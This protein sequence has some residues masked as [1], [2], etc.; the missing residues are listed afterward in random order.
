MSSI[1]SKLTSI[2]SDV[3]TIPVSDLGVNDKLVDYGF[4]SISLTKLSNEIYI[5]LGIETTPAILIE[6]ESIGAMAKYLEGAVGANEKNNTII[7]PITNNLSAPP[8]DSIFDTASKSNSLSGTNSFA[9]PR[10]NVFENNIVEQSKTS[11]QFVIATK[12][13]SKNIAIIGMSGEFPGA[14]NPQQLWQL[15]ESGQSPIKSPPKERNKLFMNVSP[16]AAGWPEDYKGGF[17]EDI[18]KFDASFFNISPREAKYLD[19]QHRLLLKHSLIALEEAGYPPKALAEKKVG[20]FIGI[21]TTDYRNIVESVGAYDSHYTTGAAHTMSANRISYFLGVT[22][23]SFIIDTAC[24]SSLVATHQAVLAIQNGDCDMAIVGG[25]NA[26]LHPG[27][28]H[29]C[30]EAG[31]LSQTGSCKVF[32]EQAD[33]YVRAEGCGV[34]ILKS[35]KQAAIDKDNILAVIRGSA[36]NHGGHVRSLTVPNP[37]AQAEV[38]KMALERAELTSEDISYI[39]THGTGTKIGDPVEVNGLKRSITKT[40]RYHRCG[41]GSVKANIGHLEAG[42]GMVGLIKVILMFKH[43]QLLKNINLKTQNSYIDLSDS[44]FFIV[45]E[46]QPWDVDSPRRA[47]ISSFGIGGSNAHIIL[48]EPDSLA[49][50]VPDTTRDFV[51]CLFSANNEVLLKQHLKDMVNYFKQHGKVSIE[52]IAYNLAICRKSYS[53]RIAIKVASREELIE[54]ITNYLAD[55]NDE[56]ILLGQS[57]VNSDLLALSTKLNI[58]L[59][60]LS[61]FYSS[62]GKDETLINLWLAGIDLSWDNLFK[63]KQQK[64]PLPCRPFDP[65]FY[66][67]DIPSVSVTDPSTKPTMFEDIVASTANSVIEKKIALSSESILLNNDQASSTTVKIALAPVGKSMVKDVPVTSQSVNSIDPPIQPT[68]PTTK[69]R[70]NKNCF[71]DE[72]VTILAQVLECEFSDIVLDKSFAEL[73]LDSILAMEFVQKINQNLSLTLKVSELYE[74]VNIKRLAT[75]IDSLKDIDHVVGSTTNNIT[76]QKIDQKA[77]ERTV[78]GVVLPSFNPHK[79]QLKELLAE[80]LAI[81]KEIISDD[82]V[83]S[84][85]GLDSILGLEFVSKI[86][87][88]FGTEL[89]VDSLY[90]YVCI[91]KLANQLA[92]V[93]KPSVDKV[94]EEVYRGQLGTTEAENILTGL[95]NAR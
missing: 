22:G 51:Y 38:I 8:Y 60:E 33:G 56:H 61:D 81:D 21:S 88:A 30:M 1:L 85:M 84:E 23:P 17:I 28:S 12:T 41:I 64:L 48:E 86:N 94:L 9:A 82:K 74:H 6:Y 39:E 18:D 43:K 49:F 37:D 2:I 89:R 26:L 29:A 62:K 55:K 13:V 40:S 93:V 4:D 45:K 44:P 50:T 66:W 75:Y 67:I 69:S 14:K 77:Q 54:K 79:D 80:V 58:S 57:V 71:L 27:L 65:K 24:S 16:F 72:L 76:S 92:I 68:V 95:N 46:N 3:T 59:N 32:D 78:T 83:F 31:M 42:A 63:A 7:R 11:K 36:T 91:N 90:E 10:S 47:G 25:V 19:P 70:P 87:K 20:V 73:G 52:Q 5:R 15:L 35:C 34:V 53:Q